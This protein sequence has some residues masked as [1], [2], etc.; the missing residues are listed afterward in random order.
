MLLGVRP[1]THDAAETLA[2][3]FGEFSPFNAGQTDT[4]SSAVVVRSRSTSR[5]PR[6]P[7]SGRSSSVTPGARG[8]DGRTGDPGPP[9]PPGPPGQDCTAEIAALR[10]TVESLRS[11]VE[12]LNER[13]NNVEEYSYNGVKE[14]LFKM[15][16]HARNPTQAS[17]DALLAAVR[18]EVDTEA[19]LNDLIAAQLQI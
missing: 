16:L 18:N 1:Q 6:V 11:T 13:L 10:A 5:G 8:R 14:V 2:L 4:P 17:F 3:T 12:S 19:S 9:G 7:R 15:V